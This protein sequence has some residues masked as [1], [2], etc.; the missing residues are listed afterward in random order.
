[1]AEEYD[2]GDLPAL[3]HFRLGAL[4]LYSGDLRQRDRIAE[5]VEEATKEAEVKVADKNKKKGN[6]K[7]QNKAAKDKGGAS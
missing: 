5:W 1:M 4:G 2:L 7:K 6:G 3:G